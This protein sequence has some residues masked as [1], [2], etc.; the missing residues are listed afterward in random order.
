M[1]LLELFSFLFQE[2]HFIVV[3]NPLEY[4][5]NRQRLYGVTVS[6]KTVL[7]TV[8]MTVVNEIQDE[9]KKF[10]LFSLR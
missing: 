6:R 1:C 9:K 5:R 2:C 3:F 8:K 7:Y 4:R 10:K